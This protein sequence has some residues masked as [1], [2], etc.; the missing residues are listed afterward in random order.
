MPLY[1]IHAKV[2]SRSAGHSAVAAAAYR[3]ASR[4][5]DERAREWRDYDRRGDSVREAHVE[6]PDGA[7]ERFRDREILWNEVERCEKRRD[8]QLCREVEFA[9]PRELGRD[10]QRELAR[11][12]VREQ[13]VDRG[14]AAD[15]AIHEGRG[16]NPHCHVM[17]AMR[18]MTSDGF[19]AKKN[20]EWNSRDLVDEW[21]QAYER[22]QNRALEREYE[23]QRTP[24]HEREYVDRRSYEE[25]G[26]DR[27]PQLHM[28]KEAWHAEERERQ[29]AEREGRE[30]E[31]VTDRGRENLEREERNRIRDRVQE[32]LREIS[33]EL[34]QRCERVVE[35]ARSLVAQREAERIREMLRNRENGR[36]RDGGRQRDRS[37][38]DGKRQKKSR[39]QAVERG[40][41]RPREQA[42]DPKVELVVERDNKRDRQRVRDLPRREESRE[43]D[44][45][46]EPRRDEAR[47]RDDERRVKPREQER[48]PERW[49]ARH[50]EPGRPRQREES[51]QIGNEGRQRDRAADE[52]RNRDAREPVRARVRDDDAMNR[53]EAGGDRETVRNRDEGRE[54]IR[55]IEPE[56]PRQHEGREPERQREPEQER[57]SASE[58]LAAIHEQLERLCRQRGVRVRTPG[59]L[60]DM[61]RAIERAEERG[62][63]FKRDGT[64]EERYRSAERATERADRQIERTYEPERYR[65]YERGYDRDDDYGRGR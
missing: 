14:M 58:R 3:S 43:N 60:R 57:G 18:E 6:L 27:E 56:K 34:R 32:R 53:H 47:V 21:R 40:P 46:R 63:D 11:A 8:A 65:G 64:L 9:L 45:P 51:R 28:G 17:L 12:Y 37:D 42:R 16:E 36:T 33:N 29:R 4:L 5:W 22:D 20:R 59:E 30:R 41:E 1:H 7:P 31:P 55:E 24:E 25:R 15:W 2:L 44:R 26:I 61:Q 13:F 10:A 54:R 62:L 35:R 52:S 23:R 19:S 38:D 49:H 50:D 48:G 39:E